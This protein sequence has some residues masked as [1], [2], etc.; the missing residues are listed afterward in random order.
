MTTQSAEQRLRREEVMV[1]RRFERYRTPLAIALAVCLIFALAALTSSSFVTKNNLIA[2]LR[3]ASVTGIVAVCATSITLSGNFF[4]VAMGQTAVLSSV[5][6]G[7]VLRANGGFVLAVLATF[8]AA[9]LVGAIQGGI[10]ELGGN[11]I[12]VTL[13]A[14]SLL[15][16]VSGAM[17]GS[18]AV[19]TPPSSVVNFI[20]SSSPLGIP[21]QTWMFGIAIV[22]VTVIA[23]KNRLGRETLLT[24]ANRAT[25]TGSGIG[26]TN[27]TVA[28]FVS[29]AV[30]AAIVGIF[31]TA[32]F[33][34]ATTTGFTTLDFDVIAAILVGGTAAGGGEGSALRS[35]LGGLFI[36]LVSNYMLLLGWPQGTITTVEGALVLVAVVTFHLLRQRAER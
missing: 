16:G 12:V 27:V 33:S 14:S 1:G 21:T 3:V 35:A 26:V 18:A 5:L 23:R 28:A 15:A 34:Q 30:G 2:V 17:T 13:G 8:G 6:F 25:A 7:V 29:A 32:Q 24:G 11:P 9:I 22:V 10:T 19:D 20:G 36:A 31:E 4:S